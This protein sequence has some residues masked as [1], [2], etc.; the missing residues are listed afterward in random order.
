MAI[1]KRGP[2]GVRFNRPTRRADER[3]SHL[4]KLLDPKKAK[5]AM[6]LDVGCDKGEIT[7]TVA[8]NFDVKEAH[9]ADVFP[10]H[11]FRGSRKIH[12]H[13]VRDNAFTDL[14]DDCMD[15]ITCFQ[16]IHHFADLHAMLAEIIRVLKPGGHLFLR[17]HDAPE[18]ATDVR[19]YVDEQHAKYDDGIGLPCSYTGRQELADLLA[20]RYHLTHLTDSVYGGRNPN[21][22]YH[23]LFCK[24]TPTV[25]TYDEVRASALALPA[26]ARRTPQ[27]PTA[28]VFLLMGTN[29]KYAAGVLAAGW[30]VK[31]HWTTPHDLVLMATPD[32]PTSVLEDLSAVFRVV[33]VPYWTVLA[34]VRWKGYA[35]LYD[36]WLS[37][38][39]TKLNIL[40]LEEY[41]KVLF[42]DGDTVAVG[43]VDPLFDLEAPAGTLSVPFDKEEGQLPH[44]APITTEAL[45]LSLKRS[46]CYGICGSAMILK[47]SREHFNAFRTRV[48]QTRW[49]TSDCNA[50]PDEELMSRHYMG[51]WTHIGRQYNC[52]SWKQNEVKTKTGADPVILHYVA[53]K[54]WTDKV[55]P[56]FKPWYESLHHAVSTHGQL[57]SMAVKAVGPRNARLVTEFDTA[58]RHG[59]FGGS[60]W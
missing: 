8:W 27:H 36:G 23:S 12:Y 24:F 54:P 32:V 31:Q 14:P 45:E 15:L 51:E 52:Q 1:N 26:T 46:D 38:V 60:S 48:L 4:T 13:E 34:T 49:R 22:I 43:P 5:V 57:R 33:P 41:E 3:V 10:L 44:G 25:P 39:L 58:S 20:T 21:A 29:P 19:K 47:P 40:T 30:S 59:A 28:V 11:K 42:L 55:W 56:D 6:Y 9:G 16:C 35:N 53:C 37:K 18:D 50:G 2:I 7:E 17:E